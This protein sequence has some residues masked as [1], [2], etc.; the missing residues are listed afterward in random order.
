MNPEEKSEW[1]HSKKKRQH[2]VA[3]FRVDFHSGGFTK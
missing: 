2:P 1:P 3:F